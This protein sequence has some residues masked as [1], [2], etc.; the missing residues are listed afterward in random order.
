MYGTGTGISGGGV[1]VSVLAYTGTGSLM[2]PLV[3]ASLALLVGAALVVRQR[4]LLSA[5]PA[6]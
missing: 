2:L 3:V 1:G 4:M 6:A 5:R